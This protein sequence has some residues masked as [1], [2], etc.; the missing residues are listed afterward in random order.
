M[1]SSILEIVVPVGI[2]LVMIGV[3]VFFALEATFMR[4]LRDQHA[5]VWK[6]LGEPKAAGNSADVRKRMRRFLKNRE[7]STLN[8]PNLTRLGDNLIVFSKVY[9]VVFGLT[10]AGFFLYRI[11]NSG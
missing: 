9:F 4:T 8:D 5:G 10:L 7:Y 2:V 1:L 6:R 3:L 11:L